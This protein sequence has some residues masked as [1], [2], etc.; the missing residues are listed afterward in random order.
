MTIQTAEPPLLLGPGPW[1]MWPWPD[2]P[3]TAPNWLFG[4]PEV[5]RLQ[6][7]YLFPREW[8]I[9]GAVTDKFPRPGLVQSFCGDTPVLVTQ[10]EHGEFACLVNSCAHRG[11][12][13][14]QESSVKTRQIRCQYHGWPYD[15]QGCLLS[16]PYGRG[17]GGQGGVPADFN[18]AKYGLKSLEVEVRNGIIFASA[19]P[20]AKL[21]SSLG[22]R[23]IYWLDQIFPPGRKLK[24]LGHFEQEVDCNWLLALLN[25]KDILHAGILHQI[26]S[27]FGLARPDAPGAVET[28]DEWRHSVLMHW[29]TERQPG[30]RLQ[31]PDE[32]VFRLLTELDGGP[33]IIMQNLGDDNVGRNQDVLHIRRFIPDGPARCRIWWDFLGFADDTQNMEDHRIL[34]GATL[35]GPAGLVTID[36]TEMLEQQQRGLAANPGGHA[37][38][39]FGGW[40]AGGDTQTALT[41]ELLRRYIERLRRQLGL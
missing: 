15:L 41:E 38:M 37:I 17:S 23:M 16:V 21:E 20:Q 36:D 6:Q 3:G 19:D 8:H 7:R 5:H 2:Q 35:Q 1:D 30:A 28:D 18:R 13:L 11:A 24:L 27:A 33:A 32:T 22:P 40:Q 9:V 31:L 39:P 10:D 14:V 25:L 34:Q 29:R 26:F 4:S 12:A